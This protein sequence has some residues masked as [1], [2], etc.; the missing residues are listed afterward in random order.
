A[1]LLML[2]RLLVADG[3]DAEA[4]EAYRRAIVHDSF[5]EQAHRELMRCYAR[6]GERGKALRHYQGLVEL[7]DAELGAQPA[8]ETTALCTRLRQGDALI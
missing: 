4:S 8:P 5:L 7:L 6:Q 3:R 1:A 2:G